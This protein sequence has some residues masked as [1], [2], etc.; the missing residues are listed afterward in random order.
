MAS[1]STN[2]FKNGLKFLLDGAPCSILNYEFVKPGKGQAFVRVTYKQ[3]LSGR[4]LEKT[5]KSGESVEAAD[6]I[7][8]EMQYL[9]NDGEEWHFMNPESFEQIALAK[10]Q[11][12]KQADYLKEQN[13]VEM[14]FW[15][16]QPINFALENFVELEV[17]DCA[18]GV[19]GDTVSG[20]NKEATLE[21]GAIIKVPLFISV[22]DILKID[23]RTGSYVSRA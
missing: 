4:T 5:F 7:Q 9:Y 1:Y 6:V 13:M 2:S 15:N 10:D 12:G 3:L 11:V 19:K 8:S 16:D 14:L 22:G 20:G 18:P 21:T 17:T 23:T